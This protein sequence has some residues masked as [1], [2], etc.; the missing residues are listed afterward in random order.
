LTNFKKVWLF[1]KCPT[2]LRKCPTF[3]FLLELV[4]RESGGGGEKLMAETDAEYWARPLTLTHHPP[5]LRNCP[6]THLTRQKERLLP[7]RSGSAEGDTACSLFLPLLAEVYRF[8]L[9]PCW[10]EKRWRGVSCAV[11]RWVYTVQ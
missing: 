5:Q 7:E 4:G 10:L 3:F 11:R 1:L 2:F 9:S 8:L 6:L